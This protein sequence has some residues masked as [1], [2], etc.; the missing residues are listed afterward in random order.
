MHWCRRY[1][2]KREF[3]TRP[4][5]LAM[6]DQGAACFDSTYYMQRNQVAACISEERLA[7]AH[8]FR[9]MDTSCRGIDAGSARSNCAGAGRAVGSFRHVWPARGAATSVLVWRTAA[10]GAGTAGGQQAGRHVSAT[11]SDA[12]LAS[13]RGKNGRPLR[14]KLQHHGCVATALHTAVQRQTIVGRI[15]DCSDWLCPGVLAPQCSYQDDL[16]CAHCV[17]ISSPGSGRDAAAASRCSCVCGSRS[18]QGQVNESSRA[19]IVDVSTRAD[20]CQPM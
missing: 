13:V 7:A 15:D 19:P 12:M 10:A 11:H 8:G 9:I 20:L 2:P 3:L 18:A 14:T 16:G 17:V 5:T 6:G 4:M 1:V